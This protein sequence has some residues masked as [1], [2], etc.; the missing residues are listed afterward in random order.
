MVRQSR[1][2]TTVQ[3]RPPPLAIGTPFSQSHAN[4]GFLGLRTALD[5]LESAI[6]AGSYFGLRS[7]CLRGATR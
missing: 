2:H 4:V 3:L 5:L 7:I 1:I 6:C